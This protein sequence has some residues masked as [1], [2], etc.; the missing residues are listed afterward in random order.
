[1]S[2][3]RAHFLPSRSARDRASPA[4]STALP[5]FSV[6]ITATRVR[7]DYFSCMTLRYR[8]NGRAVTDTRCIPDRGLTAE[9]GT[10]FHGR[11]D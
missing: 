6:T 11:C 2:H 3:P 9:W 4:R 10:L 1:M 7:H 5:R 8:L